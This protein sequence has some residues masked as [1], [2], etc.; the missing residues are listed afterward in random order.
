M[1]KPEVIPITKARKIDE[2]PWLEITEKGEAV[3]SCQ[4]GMTADEKGL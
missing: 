4:V 3:S 1:G 2:L